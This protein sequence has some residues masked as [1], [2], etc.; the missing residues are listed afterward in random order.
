[1]L[2][3]RGP[4]LSGVDTQ[5]TQVDTPRTQ[6]DTPRTRVDT[7]HTQV[8]AL[9]ARVDALRAREAALVALHDAVAE[10]SEPGRDEAGDEAGAELHARA[11]RLL[12]RLLPGVDAAWIA[13]PAAGDVP[14]RRA[15]WGLTAPAPADPPQDGL[16]VAAVHA[17]VPLAVDSYLDSDTFAHHPRLGRVSKSRLEPLPDDC[18]GQDGVV[19]D[20]EFVVAGGDTA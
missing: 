14:A 7:P 5:H 19:P 16:G 3:T 13:T 12:A 6:V 8:D 18:D 15:S 2:S 9:R 10:L 20:G 1:M 17:D 11:V 4:A